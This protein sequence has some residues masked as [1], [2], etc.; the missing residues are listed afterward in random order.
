M[1]LHPILYQ[2]YTY[3]PNLLVHQTGLEPVAYRSEDGRSN[4]TELLVHILVSNYYS[5]ALS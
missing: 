3:V 5:H 2:T 1:S 4:P